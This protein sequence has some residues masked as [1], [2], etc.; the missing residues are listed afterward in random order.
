MKM[1]SALVTTALFCMAVALPESNAS[2]QQRQQVSFKVSAENTKYI[3]S[4]NV[5][6]GDAPTHIVRLFDTRITL[7][8]N[9]PAVNGLKLVEIWARGTG[10]IADGNGSTNGYFVFLG[11]NGDKFFARTASVVES[12]SGKITATTVGHIT[13]GTGRLAE[14]SGVIRQVINIDPRPGGVPGDSQYEIEYSLGK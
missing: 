1:R 14:I 4:Q 8:N 3:V 2:A 6:V 12:A 13:G 9:A 7:P 11:E 10:E 5:D